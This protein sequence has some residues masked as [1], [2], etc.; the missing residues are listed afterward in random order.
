LVPVVP[1]RDAG[2]ARRVSLWD[3]RGSIVRKPRVSA[4]IRDGTVCAIPHHM[5]R[6]TITEAEAWSL[7]AKRL[8][9]RGEHG[10][11]LALLRQSCEALPGR[12]RVE[13]DTAELARR[14]GKPELAVLHYRRAATAYARTGQARHALT[15]LRTALHLEHSR[16]PVSA[17]EVTS[18]CRELVDAL[19]AL[20]FAGDARQVLEL[21]AG[22]FAERGL[23]VPDELAQL[24]SPVVPPGAR[25][26]VPRRG[27]SPSV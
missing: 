6:A 2:G 24:T 7:E 16:L 14:L 25:G 21:S 22:A 18:I 19:V 1:V 23:A 8:H 13:L 27:P 10:K 17:A 11:A 3:A 26:A 12:A 4:R 9:A 15:P 5:T 20:G